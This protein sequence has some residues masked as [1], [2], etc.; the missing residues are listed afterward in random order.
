MKLGLE[1]TR[2]QED[3][4]QALHQ[5]AIFVNACDSTPVEE[6]ND[7]YFDGLLKTGITAVNSTLYA[8]PEKRPDP[9]TEVLDATAKWYDILKKSTS[10]VH[11]R[12]AE[13]IEKA[14]SA[15]KIAVVFGT[16]NADFIYDPSFVKVFGVLG[17]KIMQLT[18]QNRNLIGDG[19]GEKK[20]GGLSKFGVQVVE[21]MN[22]SGIV[23]DLS[24]TSRPTSLDA[25]EVSRD[26]VIYS[27]SSVHKIVPAIRNRTDEEI[28][29]LAEKGG[30]IGLIPKSNWIRPDGLSTGTT[31]ADYLTHVGHVVALVGV[32]HAGIG[33]DIGNGRPH[34]RYGIDDPFFAQQYPE[35]SGPGAISPAWKAG[36]SIENIHP[37]GLS[38]PFPQVL[39]ITRGLVALGYS[40]QDITKILGENFMRVFGKVWK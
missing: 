15:S 1:L 13:D 24:H 6:A 29:A 34:G 23:I 26:P 36:Y 20:P 10:A 3:R 31:I 38:P 19:C 39:N 16:Q 7:E 28:K 14:K 9:L 33:L 22:R 32:N 4:A 11:V 27:H 18:Y 35:L 25:I 21:E 2:S 40:D 37:L 8:Y 17:I 12:R 30:V 5:K